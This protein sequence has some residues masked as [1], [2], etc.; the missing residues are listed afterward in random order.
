MERQEAPSRA[1]V[2]EKLGNAVKAIDSVPTALFSFLISATSTK[3]PE[4]P[5]HINSPVLRSIFYAISLGG[6]SDTTASMSGAIAGAFWGYEKIPQEILRVCEG[7]R[8][9]KRLADELFDHCQGH[10]T[11]G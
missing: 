6:D 2:V 7:S 3:F 11:N 10:Y 1:E 4:L 8:D 9:I 5:V